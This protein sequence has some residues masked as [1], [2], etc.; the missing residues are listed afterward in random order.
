M[1]EYIEFYEKCKRIG[2]CEKYRSKWEECETNK[3]IIDF[4]LMPDAIEYFITMRAKGVTISDE[5]IMEH[6]RPF[7]NGK[8]K[9]NINN[10]IDAELYF[11]HCGDVEVESNNIAVIGCDIRLNVPENTVLI[12]T[13][14]DSNIEMNIGANCFVSI[15]YY[16]DSCNFKGDLQKVRSLK[17]KEYV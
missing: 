9:S 12:L 16:G 6:F 5:Y 14:Y 11:K 17:R 1:D 2:I 10:I 13:V 7:I 15:N 8:Y 4:L 3:E